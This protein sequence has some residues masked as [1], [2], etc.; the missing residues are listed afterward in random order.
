M[1]ELAQYNLCRAYIQEGAF[2]MVA[3]HS[4]TP[5]HPFLCA[6]IS[7]PI[8][9][10]HSSKWSLTSKCSEYRNTILLAGQWY[11]Q[12]ACL[13]T[14]CRP[15]VY[16]AGHWYTSQSQWY[17]LQANGKE[18]LS[19]LQANDTHRRPMVKNNYPPCK[20][21][22]HIHVFR[23]ICDYIRIYIYIYMYMYM[24]IRTPGQHY[25]MFIINDNAM[26]QMSALVY[27]Q[28][29]VC[30]LI[31]QAT[32]IFLIFSLS[33]RHRPF[34]RAF[35]WIPSFWTFLCRSRHPQGR[36]SCMVADNLLS[37]CCCQ[38]HSLQM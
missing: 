3:A 32:K 27:C 28:N 36:L 20:P 19:S 16:L 29:S 21:F 30:E 25:Y 4:I 8:S 31:H 38:I 14:P 23:N 15:M 26:N 1:A 22:I 12:Y 18:T 13:C 2:G 7:T 10:A 24:N 5:D 33:Y 34:C 35:F 17:N 6:P 11:T 37:T 9:N